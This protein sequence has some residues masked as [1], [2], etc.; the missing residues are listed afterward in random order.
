M[1]MYVAE[2]EVRHHGGH[3]MMAAAMVKGC[4]V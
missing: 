3:G 4:M 1:L 2:M